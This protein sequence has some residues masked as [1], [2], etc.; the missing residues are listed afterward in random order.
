MGVFV[1]HDAANW[2]SDGT[3]Y[4]PAAMFY[5]LQGAWS[6]SLSAVLLMLLS[7]AKASLW[8]NLCIA[9]LVIS[10]LE[11]LQM[12]ACRLSIDNMGLVPRGMSLCD[13]ATGLPV[14]ATMTT[15]YV[16]ILA[17]LVGSW[18]WKEREE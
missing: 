14:G 18:F 10:I 9:A 1:A 12:P 15:L 5:M 11:G 17:W 3:R 16:S 7:A 2:L 13:Y 4:S 8:K 6:A